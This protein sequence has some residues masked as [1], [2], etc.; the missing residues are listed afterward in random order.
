MLILIWD[1]NSLNHFQEELKI[2]VVFIK[3][4]VYLHLLLTYETYKENEKFGTIEGRQI[5]SYE[6]SE[7]A[8]LIVKDDGTIQPTCFILARRFIYIETCR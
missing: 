1:S 4:M 3:K 7:N 2:H 8:N 6:F 5:Y